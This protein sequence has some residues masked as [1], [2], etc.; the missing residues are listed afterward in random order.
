[1][2]ATMKGSGAEGSDAILRAQDI[3]GADYNPMCDFKKR[4]NELCYSTCSNC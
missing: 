1:M 2:Q 4:L 3:D